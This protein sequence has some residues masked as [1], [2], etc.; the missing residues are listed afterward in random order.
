MLY[1]V[2]DTLEVP[3]IKHT[4]STVAKTKMDPYCAPTFIF[5]P[6]QRAVVPKQDDILLIYPG[7]ISGFHI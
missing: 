7:D 6:M 2:R 5:V 1:K 3:T 4:G